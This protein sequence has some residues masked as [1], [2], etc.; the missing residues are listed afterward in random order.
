MAAYA[1]LGLTG[2][3]TG[4]L[5]GRRGYHTEEY[6]GWPGGT[7]QPRVSFSELRDRSHVTCEMGHQQPSHFLSG[8]VR[9]A[10]QDSSRERHTWVSQNGLCAKQVGEVEKTWSGTRSAS[11]S[12]ESCWWSP[13]PR[14]S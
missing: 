10:S 2:V 5:G 13:L 7:E 4:E 9:R 3:L 1:A 8:E 11:P 14:S 12:M 6:T